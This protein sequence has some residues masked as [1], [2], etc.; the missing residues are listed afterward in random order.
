MKFS[1]IKSE[2]EPFEALIET[3]PEVQIQGS[4]IASYLL[5]SLEASFH[6]IAEMAERIDYL[7]SEL[8]GKKK[9][10]EDPDSQELEGT[11]ESTAE[12]ENS[13][14]D[15]KGPGKKLRRLDLRK[16][17][18]QKASLKARPFGSKCLTA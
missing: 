4:K 3:I 17:R 13:A 15:E 12:D 9:N 18:S 11:E 8:F 16:R 6:K 10:N 2:L 7:E 14:E 5:S 1:E